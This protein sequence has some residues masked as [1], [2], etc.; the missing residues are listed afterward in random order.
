MILEETLSL[1][2]T[3]Y[4]N[5]LEPLTISE[6]RFGVHLSAVKLSDGSY[7]I[8]ST[9]EDNGGH[10]LKKNRDFE[11]FTPAKIV[12]QKVIDLFETTK[13]S[14]IVDTLKIAVLNAIS[15]TI[16]NEGNYKIRENIDPIELVDLTQKKTITIVGAFH[17]YIQK[18]SETD[19]KLHVLELDENALVD[20]YKKF[21]AP[22]NEYQA[23]LPESDVVIITGLTLVNNTIDGL[24]SAISPDA[25][26]IVT[27][28]SSSLIPDVLFQ[29]KVNIIGATKITNPEI[30]FNIVS[31]CGAGFHLFKYC[32]AKICIINE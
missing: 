24:L 8:A 26:V 17:S 15:S 12:G 4:W 20:E 9:L 13:K 18:I 28:P 29:N 10:C 5:L 27:G 32:A 31:E 3:K 6:V 14:I 2:K 30:L 21:Y 22:A 1:L 25:L 23:V 11:E 7:G 16:L 19:N